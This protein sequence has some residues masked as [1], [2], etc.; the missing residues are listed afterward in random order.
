MICCEKERGR[1]RERRESER[2]L[3]TKLRKKQRTKQGVLHVCVA[4]LQ[5]DAVCSTPQ[6]V[7][8]AE[9]QQQHG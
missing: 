8:A 6:Q 9:L 2:V 4:M 1:E 3:L 5:C 7:L